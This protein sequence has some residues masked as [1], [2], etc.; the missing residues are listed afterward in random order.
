MIFRRFANSI[1]QCAGLFAVALT[2]IAQSSALFAQV[3][4]AESREGL[5]ELSGQDPR[6]KGHYAVPGFKVQIVASEP[7][8]IDPTAMAFDDQGRLYVSEW[9]K[10]DHMFDTFDVI[11]LPEGGTQRITRRRKASTD[12]VKR[13]EDRDKDGIY[14]HSEIVVD[15]AEMPSSIFPWKGSLYLTCVGRLEKWSDED[16]DGK[17]ETRSIVADGF[18][19]FYHHWLSGMT[20]GTDG[21]LY[22]TAGD[23][24]NHG[25]G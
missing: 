22:L 12:I 7:A 25:V 2:L 18:C 13:L 9:R 14:E 8:I 21:W 23:N 19:G 10:A 24:D 1:G 20:L 4:P 5:V 16:G 6:L 15:G 17:F 11:K 3:G